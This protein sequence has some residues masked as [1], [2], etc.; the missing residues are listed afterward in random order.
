MAIKLMYITN[1]PEIAKIAEKSGVNRIFVDMEFIGK[2]L[3]QA[4]MDTVKSHHTFDDVELIKKSISSAEL[5]VRCNPIHDRL[6]DYCSTE[7]EI[8]EIIKR[9][10]DIIMLPYFKTPEEVQRFVVAV[11]GRVK[12]MLLIETPEAAENIEEILE[13]DGID[14][15]YIGLN[16]LSLGYGKKFM[17]ELLADGTVGKLVEKIKKYSKPFGFGGMAAIGTGILPAEKIL[18]EHYRLGSTCVILARSFY[19]FEKDCNLNDV[20]KV[21]EHGVE[22][23]REEEIKIMDAACGFLDNNAY[24]IREIVEKILE[25]MDLR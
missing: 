23:I 20:S 21:F 12:T 9:G 4:N 13:I 2:E 14:E 10:A 5:L 24:E 15:V 11:G 25:E 7:E 6:D 8:N 1:R 19:N 22:K 17:F 3:R 18:G 16:D